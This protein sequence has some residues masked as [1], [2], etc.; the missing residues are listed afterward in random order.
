MTDQITSA[1][2]RELVGTTDGPSEVDAA[3]YRRMIGNPVSV[4]DLVP[5]RHSSE[6]DTEPPAKR[7]FRLALSV[8]CPEAVE[9]YEFLSDRKFRADWALVDLK[10][11]IEYDGIADHATVKGAW[12]DAEKGNLAQ[13]AGWLFLRV[14]AASINDGRAVAWVERAMALRRNAA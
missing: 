7:A 11:L 5:R 10:V 1:A 3:T 6:A 12:R 9:E 13:L 14:N 2:Y 8:I 4:N